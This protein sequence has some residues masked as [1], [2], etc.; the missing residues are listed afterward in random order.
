MAEKEIIEEVKDETKP[1][2][3]IDETKPEEVETDFAALLEGVDLN[4]LLE[5]DAV[6]TLVGKQIDR[7]VQ[8]G[9][10][11]AKTKW[12]KA[13]EE[14]KTEAKKLEQMTEEQK[15]RYKLEQEKSELETAK[16]KFAHDQLVVETQKQMISAGLPDLAVYITG[17]TA[18]ETT[19]N[20]N[21]VTKLLSTWKAEQLN[22]AMRGKA[23][24]D[25]NPKDNSSKLTK[26]ETD[27]MS[28][29]ELLKAYREGRIDY[30]QL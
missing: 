15:E 7:R 28:Q 21:A 20:L 24:K 26:A 8:Q 16:A 14:A 17:D 2:E 13:Q 27:K 3:V 29:A 23:P 22:K 9:V 19:A 4:K 1:E 10:A 5:F 30:S 11:T 6:K 12:L 18:E 25:T